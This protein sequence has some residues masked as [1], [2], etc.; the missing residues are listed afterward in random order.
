MRIRKLFPAALILIAAGA[1]I[2]RL[3]RL[4][5]RPMH[6][7]EA[8]Q[9]DKFRQLWEERRWI[10]DPHEYHG[11]TLNYFTA[12]PMWL[13]R[14]KDFAHSTEFTYR[15]VPVVFG[16]G[17]ILLLLLV[18]DGMGRRSAVCA[19]VLIAI[20]PA[21][22]FYSRYYIQE[23]LLVF[24]TFGAIA[25]GWRFLRSGQGT[26]AILAGVCVGLMHATKETFVL[27]A[28]AAVFAIAAT[29][30]WSRIIDPPAPAT[31][32]EPRSWMKSR[33]A[34]LLGAVATAL[35]ISAVCFSALFTNSRAILQSYTTYLNYFQ[36]G[37]GIG[38]HD[39]PFAWYFQLYYYFT[40]GKITFS[41]IL[42]PCLA[43][44]GMLA[45]L[46]KRGRTLGGY[47]N[48]FTAQVHA[49]PPE[50]VRFLTFYT[51][52]ITLIYCVIRYKT[53]WCGLN[54]HFP[55]ILLA[56]VGAVAL[57]Q[58]SRFRYAKPVVAVA[59]V[60]PAAQLSFQAY[61]MNFQQKPRPLYTDSRANPHVYGH[62]GLQVFDIV[63]H[64]RDVAALT[65]QK[66]DT[67]VLLVS[68]TGDVWPL[69]W[70]LR[71]FSMVREPREMSDLPP[72]LFPPLVVATMDAVGSV[73]QYLGVGEESADAKKPL[74]RQYVIDHYG[75][76]TGVPVALYIRKDLFNA[77]LRSRGLQP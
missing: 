66:N 62:P 20:S 42:I 48:S 5:M 58:M 17:L 36:R 34:W 67:P 1:F 26:Y 32:A 25:C 50:L 75:L 21:M 64:I 39:H 76:R 19:G 11:P 33:I 24:F 77:Y 30:V 4:D 3:P 6:G 45:S 22:V 52:A 46:W 2:F 49:S 16:T 37:T 7:D 18:G 60:F 28:A 9:A 29:K 73:D 23:M 12:V 70:Y 54:F 31:A 56:G 63:Q 14:A 38:D 8:I 65:P 10:Y 53:P 55:L 69:P 35:V 61:R 57:V 71:D 68:P 13:T 15:I 72:G 51:L 41:E 47:Y 74:A 44:V 43:V 40:Y 27:S 59:L